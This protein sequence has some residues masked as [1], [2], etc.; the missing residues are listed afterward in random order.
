MK[1]IIFTNVVSYYSSEEYKVDLLGTLSLATVLQKNKN[2]D[3]Q[4]L[5]FRYEYYKGRYQYSTN[6][7]EEVENMCAYLL[8]R[9]PD[10]IDIYTMCDTYHIAIMLAKRIKEINK[11]IKIVFGGPQATLTAN[12]TL[13]AF[14]WIDVI[15]LGEGESSIEYIMENLLENKEFSDELGVAYL[16]EGK[17]VN[18]GLPALIEDLD[19]LPLLDYSYFE[20]DDKSEINIEAGRGCP[21][22]CTFCS[23]KSF[24]QRKFRLKS[25]RRIVD[26]VKRIKENY[27]FKTYSFTHDL[28]TANKRKVLELCDLLIE[29]NLGIYWA[30]SS[31]VDTLDE[32]MIA[33]M[34]ESG[35]KTVFLG[36]ETG[37]KRMQKLLKKNLD[38]SKVYDV[39]DL[40]IKYEIDY[41]LSFI[42]GF[43]NETEEDVRDT[44]NLIDKLSRKNLSLNNV[45]LL[46]RLAFFS[47]TE[48]SNNHFDEMEYSE[49]RNTTMM[50]GEEL[51]E[52]VLNMI[53]E[54]KEVFI[55]FYEYETELR[56]RLEWLEKFMPFI[57]LRTLK[58]YKVTYSLLL[59]YYNDDILQMF[60]DY[61]DCELDTLEVVSA[62]N[63][64]VGENKLFR[65]YESV[66]D[67]AQKA[68]FGE[69][70]K[71]I[72]Q[73]ALFE[74]NVANLLHN[75]EETEKI[76]E[77][78]LDVYEVIRTRQVTEMNQKTKIKFSRTDRSNVNVVKVS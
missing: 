11:D 31:R 53:K 56:T 35:C 61:K 34:A 27:D 68:N 17:V 13:E 72:K 43:P 30:C 3:V 76:V 74:Y 45:L 64:N 41:K 39:V 51:P 15:G 16:K 5:D 58:R 69:L 70:D 14:P 75:A 78:E 48:L 62:Y 37:S 47:G 71:L 18:N 60:Y 54:H 66:K 57:Y 8:D 6:F 22:G 2:Y 29:E 42:Y 50:Y 26:E 52:I 9:N 19:Q 67:F 46:H 25:S 7:N 77:F 21:F 20:L 44:L 63:L 73:V 65:A 28:F 4:I 1:K 40:L 36:I 24:W 49:K 59:Q 38:I 12:A 23:T 10:V 55:Q 33:K 32:E